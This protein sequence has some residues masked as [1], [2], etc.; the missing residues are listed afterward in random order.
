[1]KLVINYATCDRHGQCAGAA[2]NLLGF[3]DDGAIK[4][5]KAELTD[6]DLEEARDACDMCPTQSLELVE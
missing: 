6:D 1:M 2:P 5:L 4:L 3:G